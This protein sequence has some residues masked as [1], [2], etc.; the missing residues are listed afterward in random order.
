MEKIYNK[1]GDIDLIVG[2]IAE[3][4]LKDAMVGPTLQCIIGE[5][6]VRS[7]VGDRY[8]YDNR[9]QPK[10]FSKGIKFI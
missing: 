2:T 3:Y 4:P 9:Q 5:Q 10:P 6:F 8:F 7:K 1:V